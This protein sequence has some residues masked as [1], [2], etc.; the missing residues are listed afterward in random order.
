MFL[1]MLR[2][3]Q[4]WTSGCFH[5]WSETSIRRTPTL[6]FEDASEL[7]IDI[8]I[9][10]ELVHGLVEAFHVVCCFSFTTMIDQRPN[11]IHES[12]SG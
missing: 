4:G 3:K 9:A 1:G 5:S 11:E 2:L 6:G 8:S 7:E 12:E 10:S